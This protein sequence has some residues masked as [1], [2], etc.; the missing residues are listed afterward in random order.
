MS[1]IST[2]SVPSEILKDV[3]EKTRACLTRLSAHEPE[4][5]I[6][7]TVHAHTSLAA[8]LVLLYED[9]GA[10]RVLLT[11][12]AK[13]MHCSVKLREAYEEIELPLKSPHVHV[14]CTLRPFVSASRLIVGPVVA[15]LSAP[16]EVIPNLKASETEVDQ[17]F[18][19]PFEALLNS[20]LAQGEPLVEKGGEHWAY[21][22]EL[23]NF[24]DIPT[25]WLG[26]YRLHR[27]RTS[28]SPLK[29]LT[30]E[31]LLETA[32]IAYGRESSVERWAPDQP[33]GA[34]SVKM[35]LEA[36]RRA[37]TAETP[38]AKGW[39]HAASVSGPAATQEAAA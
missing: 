9:A 18:S 23:H 37:I 25:A 10:L 11:T 22:E 35:V 32:E 1:S 30:A 27:F 15:F 21:D 13:T 17:I 4:L 12:R 20:E 6:D 39:E 2:L 36:A 26:V 7:P 29:G 28:H 38:A 24:R 19:H 8:V 14:L 3:S 16:A 31:V 34:T 5:I 33:R